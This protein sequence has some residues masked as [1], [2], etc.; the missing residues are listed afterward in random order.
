M[1]LFSYPADRAAVDVL[2]SAL[3]KG[4]L[5]TV[6]LLAIARCLGRASSSVRAAW[7][8]TGALAVL[9]VPLL[10]SLLPGWSIGPFDVPETLGRPLSGETGAGVPAMLLVGLAVWGAGVVV[11]LGRLLLHLGRIVAITDR[12]DDVA[13]GPIGDRAREIA[14]RMGLRR[15]VRVILSEG[16]RVPCT[17]GIRHPVVLLPAA[18]ATWPRDLQRAVLN[19]ELAHVARGDY[20]GLLWLELVRVLHWPNPFA[21]LL[22]RAGRQEQELACDDA[23]VRAGIPPVEYARHL[24]AIGRHVV[25]TSRSPV[26]ALPMIRASSLKERVASILEPGADR[27]PATMARLLLTGVVIALLATP[28]AIASPSWAC[29]EAAPPVQA[30]TSQTPT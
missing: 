14:R 9:S 23:A 29:P 30:A 26:A 28:V 10:T 4:G 24:V 2:L 6:L 15:N 21:W 1:E 11:L 17:W 19:H 12:G 3:I 27:R 13:G 25:G 16:V 5:L 20:M 18:A 8:T 22:R 7:C